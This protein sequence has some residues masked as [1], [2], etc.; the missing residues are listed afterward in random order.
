MYGRIAVSMLLAL[1]SAL[2][3]EVV[4]PT[5]FRVLAGGREVGEADA[6]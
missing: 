5:R 2:Q 3:A 4:R 6:R 1:A